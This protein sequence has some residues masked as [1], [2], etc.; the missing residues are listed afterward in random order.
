MLQPVTLNVISATRADHA[1]SLLHG[2]LY[3]DDL[4]NIV[5]WWDKFSVC[6][7]NKIILN[8]IIAS[9]LIQKL[10]VRPKSFRW[11]SVA[12]AHLCDRW[13]HIYIPPNCFITSLNSFKLSEFLCVLTNPCSV[14][15]SLTTPKVPIIPPKIINRLLWITIYLPPKLTKLSPTSSPPCYAPLFSPTL[16]FPPPSS[17]YLLTSFLNSPFSPTL[18]SLI[19]SCFICL[20]PQLLT[21]RSAR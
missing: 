17:S 4:K 11:T 16:L 6:K 14:L 8:F 2:F 5:Y 7:T 18:S 19:F 20:P 9:T 12:I 13:S 3:Y 1:S 21:L 15:W 10:I